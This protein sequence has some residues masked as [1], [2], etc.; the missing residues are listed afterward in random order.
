MWYGILALW[1]IWSSLLEIALVAFFRKRI[2]GEHADRKDK[3][4]NFVYTIVC[5][6]QWML[7]IFL[8]P[9][10]FPEPIKVTISTL[11]LGIQLVGAV[12]TLCIPVAAGGITINKWMRSVEKIN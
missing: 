3:L 7:P 12:I 11:S 9:V 10:F 2:F 4:N 8:F 1:L 5:L 6:L